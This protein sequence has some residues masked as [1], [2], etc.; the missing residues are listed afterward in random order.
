MTTCRLSSN[1]NLSN[2]LR[3]NI[4]VAQYRKLSYAR[5]KY[6]F[7]KCSFNLSNH[8]NL[9][10]SNSKSYLVNSYDSTHF[11]INSLLKRTYSSKPVNDEDDSAATKVDELTAE[12]SQLDYPVTHSLPATVVVPEEWPQVPLIAVSRHPVFPRFIKLLEVCCYLFYVVISDIN[13]NP[14]K[15]WYFCNFVFT[16]LDIVLCSSVVISIFNCVD[17]FHEK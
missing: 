2:L 6:D 13:L 8:F 10:I 1:L 5:R 15:I 4:S 16:R 17:I 14:R 9:P 12:S 11:Q 3:L 7:L